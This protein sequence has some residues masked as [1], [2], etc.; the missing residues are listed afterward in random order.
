MTVRLGATPVFFDVHADTF[1]TDP[2]SLELAIAK[3]RELEPPLASLAGRDALTTID[4][5]ASEPTKPRSAVRHQAVAAFAAN[6]P[7]GCSCGTPPQGL[8]A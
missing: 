7:G 1:N 2:R 5:C 6:L 8:S 3:A 4:Q